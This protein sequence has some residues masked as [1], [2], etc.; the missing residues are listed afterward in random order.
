MTRFCLKKIQDWGPPVIIFLATIVWD[1][2]VIAL[3]SQEEY[4]KVTPST[5]AFAP[6]QPTFPT[7]PIMPMP[8]PD[9]AL[10]YDLKPVDI[11]LPTEK[12]SLEDILPTSTA[13]LAATIEA[14]TGLSVSEEKAYTLRAGEGVNSILLRAGYSTSDAATA[15][16]AA[17]TKASLRK[18]QIGMKFTVA[19]HGFRF[20][21]KPGIDIY[22][23]RHPDF[24]WIALNTVRPL[25]K[26]VAFIQGTID[27]S[28]YKAAIE[29][30]INE[31]AFQEYVR[32]MGFS[33]KKKI[34]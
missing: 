24:G 5:V 21:V 9:P 7:W 12:P 31:A 13:T 10:A 23:V 16:E 20:S 15:I 29:A 6:T 2:P 11:N 26:Y 19:S 14:Q 4:G 25:E 30:G 33:V 3:D 32:V 1:N 8:R 18:L 27:K 28:I 22:V 34:K 17:Q